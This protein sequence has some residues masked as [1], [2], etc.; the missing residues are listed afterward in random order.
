[1]GWAADKVEALIKEGRSPSEISKSR[2]VSQ[3]VTLRTLAALVGIGRLRRS[4][5]FYS[6]PATVRHTVEN[7]IRERFTGK[8]QTAEGIQLS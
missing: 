6:I 3:D 7:T 8:R 2:G 1:M 5:I 4:D